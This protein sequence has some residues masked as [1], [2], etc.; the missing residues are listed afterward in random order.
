MTCVFQSLLIEEQRAL[1]FGSSGGSARKLRSIL[2]C[3][4]MAAVGEKHLCWKYQEPI[5]GEHNILTRYLRSIS[6]GDIWSRYLGAEISRVQISAPDILDRRSISGGDRDP[7]L[8]E[9]RYL[10]FRY[11]EPIFGEHCPHCPVATCSWDPLSCGKGSRKLS[12]Q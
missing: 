6:V 2:R 5:F 3:G 10:E 9:L 12:F 7:I 1:W 11:L 8:G 4:S